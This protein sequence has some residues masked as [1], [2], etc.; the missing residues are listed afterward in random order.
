MVDNKGFFAE[1][2]YNI[3]PNKN[4]YFESS[5]SQSSESQSS[6]SVPTYEFENHSNVMHVRYV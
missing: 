6:K 4:L 3:E 2:M 1:P 5:K